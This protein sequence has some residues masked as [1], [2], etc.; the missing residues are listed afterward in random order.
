MKILQLVD[1]KGWAIDRLSRLIVRY[2]PDIRFRVLYVHPREV[3]KHI[4]EVKDNLE[5]ADIVDFQY[6]NSARQLLELIPE[7]DRKKKILSHHNQKDLLGYNWA[8]INAH[9]AHT[10]YSA[11]VLS[12]AGYENV[13]MIPY[14]IDQ[15]FFTYDEDYMRQ[16]PAIGYVGRITPWK[17]LRELARACF[18][19]DVKLLF[20]GKMD[21][22]DYW[23]TIPEEHRAHID[24][25][26]MDA[27]D[28]DRINFYR[29]LSIYVGNSNNGRE[30]G[31][32]GL[33]EAMAC[34]VPVITTPSGMAADI[35]DGTN[36]VITPFDDYESLKG[37]I[38]RLLA[39]DDQR[40]ELRKKAWNTIK[41]FTEERMA[42]E[43]VKVYHQVYSDLPLISVVIPVYNAIENVVKILNGLQ[44]AKEFYEHFEV[45]VCDDGSDDGLHGRINNFREVY[46]FPIKYVHN[47]SFENGA[48]E[49]EIKPDLK[50][51]DFVRGKHYGLAEA[52]NRG[53]IAA[54]G[55]YIMSCDSRMKPAPDAMSVFM[56]K[57][58][59]Q[60]KKK[61]WLFGDK[62]ANKDAFVENFSF[63]R[64]D[65]LIRAGMFNERIDRYGG[66]SQE[67]RTRFQSQGFDPI[68]VPEA[69]ATQLSSS[70]LTPERRQDIIKSKLLLWK[71]GMKG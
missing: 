28:E 58:V 3:E 2:N 35:I 60:K 32:Q 5:W 48:E 42:W 44:E 59:E 29:E 21:K 23:E 8:G 55:E 40:A 20:M 45:V 37:N 17:G 4:D 56:K 52:R 26:Y 33:L 71:M 19:L 39:D 25:S 70:H 38:K 7:L 62:G 51:Y 57:M 6:W 54:A 61:V 34:G 31:T 41:L 22:K 15:D 10:K 47:R 13:H 43:F 69:K 24:F 30:E 11:E 64:R 16:V 66:M 9:V 53:V 49:M 27:S 67:L 50:T 46:D 36:G 68:Y 18:E 1:S 65:H 63:I 12:G 14:G